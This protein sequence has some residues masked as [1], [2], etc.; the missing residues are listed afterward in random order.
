MIILGIMLCTYIQA[1][2]LLCHSAATLYHSYAESTM[3]SMLF[4]NWMDST[5][6]VQVQAYIHAH[7]CMMS[8]MY[9]HSMNLIHVVLI[10]L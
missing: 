2:T 1:R 6:Q 5:G 7:T 10:G 3:Y 8:I 9:I 4:Y